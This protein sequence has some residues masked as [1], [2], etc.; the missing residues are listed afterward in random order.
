MEAL[1]EAFRD[2]R[3]D[4]KP[5][6]IV[7]EDIHIYASSSR[8]SL[9]YAILDLLHR[10]DLLFVVIGLT[11]RIDFNQMLEKR[12]ASRLN[13]QYVY[14]AMPTG[15]VVCKELYRRLV[16]SNESDRALTIPDAMAKRFNASI[17]TVFSPESGTA[18][19]L[20]SAYVGTHF[21]TSILLH[22]LLS[23]CVSLLQIM[24]KVLSS[25]FAPRNYVSG[26]YS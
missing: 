22:Y 25:L 12:V 23:C 4:R 18:L 10:R 11:D 16:I 3:F 5:T 17:E 19:P 8:Q 9:L 20:V 21:L 6:V 7:L 26:K 2:S 13:A 24:G 1:E 14:M 15:A